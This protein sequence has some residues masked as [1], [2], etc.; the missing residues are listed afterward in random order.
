VHK[1]ITEQPPASKAST[2]APTSGEYF[3]YV[4]TLLITQRYLRGHPTHGATLSF[5][6]HAT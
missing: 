2:Y 6:M 3:A 4:G 5:I 1:I